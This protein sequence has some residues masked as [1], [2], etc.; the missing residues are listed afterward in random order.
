MLRIEDLNIVNGPDLYLVLSNK[1]PSFWNMDYK[2]VGPLRAN[3]GSFNLEVPKDID[4]G[5]YKY[6]LIHC[7]MFSHTFASATIHKK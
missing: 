5:D 4:F 3:I 2:I 1:K 7:R 6:L